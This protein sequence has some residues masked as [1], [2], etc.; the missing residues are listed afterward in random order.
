MTGR[1][2]N[3]SLAPSSLP[4]PFATRGVTSGLNAL[5]GSMLI[6]KGHIQNSSHD[7]IL[8]KLQNV[9]NTCMHLG[10]FQILN[11]KQNISFVIK[12]HLF[13][14]SYLN[15]IQN[16]KAIFFVCQH[17]IDEEFYPNYPELPM[18]IRLFYHLRDKLRI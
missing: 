18:R 7:V 12:F 14:G 8:R 17:A 3:A 6:P 4:D 11:S 9:N 15:P 1:L 13:S 16:L 2:Y 10:Q 5:F